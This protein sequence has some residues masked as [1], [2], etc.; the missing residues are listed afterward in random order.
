[1]HDEDF[2]SRYRDNGKMTDREYER[3]YDATIGLRG[4]FLFTV[5][6][7][8]SIGVSLDVANFFRIW[9]AVFGYAAFTAGY[10]A[11]RTRKRKYILQ[12]LISA[13]C[14]GF[15]LVVFIFT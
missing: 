5:A 3:D 1:M 6:I 8:C 12:F 10:F 11:V 14:T 4:V 9:A 7:V 15:G 2:L 13:L